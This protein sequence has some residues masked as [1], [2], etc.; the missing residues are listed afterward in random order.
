VRPSADLGHLAGRCFKKRSRSLR[1]ARMVADLVMRS[2]V[3][4]TPGGEADLLSYVLFDSAYTR[5]LIALGHADAQRQAD[6]IV[7]LFR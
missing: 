2:T 5:E 7:E 3:G 4:G 1:P 6:E